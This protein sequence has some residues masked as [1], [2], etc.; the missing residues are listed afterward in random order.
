VCLGVCVWEC[1]VYRPALS[2]CVCVSERDT[3]HKGSIQRAE[4]WYTWTVLEAAR[5]GYSWLCRFK[6][7]IF[8]GI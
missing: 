4:D 2:V 7:H 1:A 6:P 5:R 8:D 3:D